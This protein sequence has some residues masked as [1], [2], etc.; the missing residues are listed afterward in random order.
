MV[1][2][3]SNK[4]NIFYLSIYFCYIYYFIKSDA[5]RKKL[6]LYEIKFNQGKYYPWKDN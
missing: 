2:M 3:N 4:T 1:I 6:N 5:K